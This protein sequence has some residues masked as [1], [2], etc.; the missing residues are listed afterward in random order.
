MT[1][2]CKYLPILF[3]A[4]FLFSLIEFDTYVGTEPTALIPPFTASVVCKIRL[5]LPRL[6]EPVAS[7][8]KKTFQFVFHHLDVFSF[9]IL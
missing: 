7:T 5:T 9:M 8:L 3:L 1:G 2:N 6:T 4:T